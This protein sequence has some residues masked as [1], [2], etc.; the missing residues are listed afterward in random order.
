MVMVGVDNSSQHVDLQPKVMPWSEGQKWHST[1]RQCKLGDLFD[2]MMITAQ[3]Y[4]YGLRW[5]AIGIH[6]GNA[7]AGLMPLLT[8]NALEAKSKTLQLS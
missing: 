1:V 4:Y 3:H 2:I 5:V 7:V 8:P 6:L